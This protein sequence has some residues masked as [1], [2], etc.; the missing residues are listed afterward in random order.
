MTGHIDELR[1]L[2]EEQQERIDE[3]EEEQ[4]NIKKQYQA[5]KEQNNKV[6]NLFEQFKSGGISRRTFLSSV[7]AVA[8]LGWL[9][10]SARGEPNWSNATGNSGEESKPLKNVYAQNAYHQSVST[11]E[12]TVGDSISNPET[13]LNWGSSV[14]NIRIGDSFSV[15]DDGTQKLNSLQNAG[16]ATLLQIRNTD[17]STAAVVAIAS[18]SASIIVSDG[19]WSLSDTDGDNC[20]L[21]PGGDLSIKNRTGSPKSYRIILNQVV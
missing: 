4:A 14:G 13:V 17:D 1:E 18:T 5:T 2:V 19:A 10:G 3:L 8:G 9:A 21:T 6:L 7:T 11:K 15:S 12:S 16:R 20:I